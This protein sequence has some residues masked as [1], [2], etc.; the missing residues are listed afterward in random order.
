MLPEPATLDE[1]QHDTLIRNRELIERQGF[2]FEPLN[3][4]CWEINA[5]PLPLTAPH[6]PRPEHI[7]Q[8]LLDEFVTEQLVSS[9]QQAIAATIA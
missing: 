7:L 4:L 5:L 1:F 6:C 9:P 8:R 2:E 3:D